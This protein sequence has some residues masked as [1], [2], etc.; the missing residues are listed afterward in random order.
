MI[1]SYEFGKIV[2]DGKHYEHDVIIFNDRVKSDWW[3]KESHKL[4]IED[5]KEVLKQKIKTL[6]IGTGHDAMMQ[7]DK[8][9]YDY[10]DDNGINLVVLPTGEAVKV[11]NKTYLEEGVVAALHLTC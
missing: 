6:I 7:V 4:L 8:E 2:V 9:M 5:I 1:D 10:C 3:R 11:Y